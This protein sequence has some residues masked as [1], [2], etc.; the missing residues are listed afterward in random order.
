MRITGAFNSCLFGDGAVSIV[1]GNTSILTTCLLQGAFLTSSNAF[2]N[3]TDMQIFD[4]PNALATACTILRGVITNISGSGNAGYG[5]GLQNCSLVRYPGAT[6]NLL[7]ALSNGRLPTAPAINLSLPQ[8]LQTSDYAQQG[9][10]GAMTAGAITVTVPWYENTT[11]RVTATH[12]VFAGTP[13]ILS[14]QQISTTQF[15]I[16]SS[17]ALDTSTVNWQISPLGRNIFVSTN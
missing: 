11:Q 9:I 15:T 4:V 3:A 6:N 13:G 16:T 12:A 14:V 17:S 7:G 10:T 8:L 5:I 2:V 1:I